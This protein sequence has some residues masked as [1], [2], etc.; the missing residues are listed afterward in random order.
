MDTFNDASAVNEGADNLTASR[1]TTH[2]LLSALIPKTE[3][4]ALIA[5]GIGVF[6]PIAALLIVQRNHVN[7]PHALAFLIAFSLWIASF[8]IRSLI[9]R[10]TVQISLNTVILISFAL[11]NQWTANSWQP[12]TH[13]TF[14]IAMA[15]AFAFRWQYALAV[16][17]LLTGIDAV[18]TFL[19][20]PSLNFNEFQLYG[21]KFG[22]GLVLMSATGLI[23]AR[24]AWVGLI[25]DVDRESKALLHVF[26]IDTQLGE[27]R[28]VRQAVISR[29]H[30][31]LLNTLDAIS[32]GSI[33]STMAQRSA[34][35]DITLLDTTHK[36]GNSLTIN[37]VVN[38]AIEFIEGFDLTVR[39]SSDV[40][41]NIQ[42]S[43]VPILVDAISEALNNAIRHS[44]SRI[45][46][47]QISA[48]A[49]TA[50]VEITDHGR[51][52][53][54]NQSMR[55]GLRSTLAGGM[56]SINGSASFKSTKDV[57]TTVALAFPRQFTATKRLVFFPVH[58]LVD[59]SF[60]ARLGL[61][62]TNLF[63]LFT[64]S[65]ISAPLIESKLINAL[66]WAF[67]GLNAWLVLYWNSSLRPWV[68]S[69]AGL[70][71]LG[72]TY[73]ATS[74]PLGCGAA[75]S[76]IWII[77]TFNGGGAILVVLAF[78]NVWM[79][80]GVVV[81]FATLGTILALGLPASC[82]TSSAV[83][84]IIY[85]AYL[86]SAAVFVLWTHF[87]FDRSRERQQLGSQDLYEAE[88]RSETRRAA[89]ENGWR[90]VDQDTRD[91]LVRIAQGS[92]LADS[93][94]AMGHAATCSARI[95]SDINQDMERSPTL[96]TII[97]RLRITANG[98]GI[99][100]SPVELSR[101]TREDPLPVP[102][103]DY[104]L[105]AL[106]SVSLKHVTI[107]SI[108]DEDED[109]FAMLIP[110]VQSLPFSMLIAQ[111]G[112][113]IEWTARSE[114]NEVRLS[115]RRAIAKLPSDH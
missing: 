57:G 94:E 92:L 64:I 75:G 2:V 37:Q 44:G 112:C 85:S 78:R 91:L 68:A 63:L 28:S 12:A 110:D 26:E 20:P 80:V 47:I 95:R 103:V 97:D 46:E 111:S 24:N 67:I 109:E 53:S 18:I 106:R 60:A 115:I 102:V 15:A 6:L 43:V 31:T 74:S 35:R 99:G 104:F 30:G 77:T 70:C 96:Q 72:V 1:T 93:L 114:P 3:N 48:N 66:A 98:L 100:I 88:L 45:V 39:V 51:G 42:E 58:H 5:S 16:V 90:L 29:I 38:R 71:V 84:V 101:P 22:A 81:F 34:E 56:D 54:Q 113:L 73:L 41:F 23:L 7:A 14:A 32:Q 27:L 10:A 17:V 21:W 79:R 87:V 59:H 105:L 50:L 33:D 107:M 82:S 83:S 13:T 89:L 25:S 65:A 49:L 11:D 4:T 55:L 86:A 19:N 76:I 9:I 108:G 61:F 69:S 52:M 8:T 40:D 62:A 36:I